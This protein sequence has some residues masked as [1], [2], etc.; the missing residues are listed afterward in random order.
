M[1][2]PASTGIGLLIFLLIL[3]F[4]IETGWAVVPAAPFVTTNGA[5]KV[6]PS[7]ATL[8][9]SIRPYG[10]KTRDIYFEYGPG[11]NY[12]SKGSLYQECK[13][14]SWGTVC[15]AIGEVKNLAP[16]QTYH[17]RLVVQ[18]WNEDYKQW[19]LVR[20]EDRTFSTHLPATVTT[21]AATGVTATS[22][23]LHGTVNPNGNKTKAY[24]DYSVECYWKCPA[25]QRV[26]RD[27][28][29]G[30]GPVAVS[31][32]VS[33][34][35]QGKKYLVR[36]CAENEGGQ[37]SGE[38]V[39]FFTPSKPAV[40]TY[41][42]SAI[43]TRSA[44][45]N[46]I[47]TPAALDTRYYFEYGETA[48]Y[49]IKKS[50]VY[51]GKGTEPV[52]ASLPLPNSFQP[53]KTYHFRLVAQNTMG[54]SHG[55]DKIF[56]T[57]KLNAPTVTTG[58]VAKITI[59]T[60]TLNGIVNP[61][62]DPALW[63]FEYRKAG[64]GAEWKKTVGVG[65]GVENDWGISANIWGLD[66]DTLYS[67]KIVATNGGG[68]ATGAERSFKTAPL[69]LPGA[70]TGEAKY[71]TK[72]SARLTGTISPNGVATSYWF[73]FGKTKSYKTHTPGKTGMLGTTGIEVSEDIT[74]LTP[75]TVYYYRISASNIKG[76]AEGQ[77]KTFSTASVPQEVA[78]GPATDVTT[79]GAKL[80]GTLTPNG[81]ST[82]WWFE[83]GPT[84]ALGQKTGG[85]QEAS[86]SGTLAVS[87]GLSGLKPGA[88][89][90]YRIGSQASSG[91]A[92][93]ATKTFAT[94]K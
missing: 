36:L 68:T 77:D 86:L 73:W 7:S 1:K 83:Y 44:T 52:S 57:E 64:S 23:V 8:N 25:P 67:Y 5:S 90:Y 35:T 81:L 2:K 39:S 45:L 14:Y 69:A 19:R 55:E 4:G 71:V 47:V 56:T 46:G 85:L 15:N 49:G 93:G 30:N 50:S 59:G 31:A 17:F 84:P 9:G 94:P 42:A 89:Y 32:D 91:V 16:Q 51:A 58:N 63:H 75:N 11:P 76:A 20:G 33:G 61:H 21:G 28:A 24:F 70:T 22:A 53:G 26:A 13:S 48:A 27:I 54:T 78:T 18:Y 6:T 88:T 12:G 80:T 65:A 74:G 3:V 38:Y 82:T 62:N 72:S 10:H 40:K 29:P 34:L 79:N 66:P 60:A 87:R 37:S 92:Y 41:S 43:G